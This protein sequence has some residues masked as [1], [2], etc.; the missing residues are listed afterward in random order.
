MKCTFIAGCEFLEKLDFTVNFIGDLL[1]VESLHGNDHLQELYLTGNPCTE[2]RGYREFT[3]ATLPSLR[4]LDGITITRSERIVASQQLETLRAQILK[5][6]MVYAA[7]RNEEK[8]MFEERE[9]MANDS[10]KNPG[11]DGRWYTDPQAHVNGRKGEEEGTEEAYTPEYRMKN[12]REMT[13]K[14]NEQAKEPE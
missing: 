11:F 1:S 12:H 8:R 4:R 14:R 10:T 7:R 9:R 5:Q 13:E 3:V 6:Q 2:Y